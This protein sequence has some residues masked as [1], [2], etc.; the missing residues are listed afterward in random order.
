MAHMQCKCLVSP[1]L[2]FVQGLI[3]VALTLQLIAQM[4]REASFGP[5]REQSA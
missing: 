3:T 5:V 1:C 4:I 2:P